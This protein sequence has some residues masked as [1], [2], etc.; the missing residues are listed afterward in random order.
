MKID[1][2][3]SIHAL[4]LGVFL[5]S[6]LVVSQPLK[7]YSLTVTTTD[8]RAPSGQ[9]SW[10]GSEGFTWYRHSVET[11]PPANLLTFLLLMQPP[12]FF[13]ESRVEA[14][15]ELK[16]KHYKQN[17]E[18]NDRWVPDPQ[19]LSHL[20][21]NTSRV[22]HVLQDYPIDIYWFFCGH[23]RQAELGPFKAGRYQFTSTMN[24]SMSV[25]GSI[26]FLDK[27]P[28]LPGPNS[29]SKVGQIDFL[30]KEDE[31]WDWRQ[32]RCKD[33]DDEEVEPN[34]CPDPERMERL[35][36]G[37]CVCK[38]PWVINP[39]VVPLDCITLDE[40]TQILQDQFESALDELRQIWVDHT[41]RWAVEVDVCWTVATEDLPD[42]VRGYYRC[43][44]WTIYYEVG[45]SPKRAQ[46]LVHD[47][48]GW[49]RHPDDP[50]PTAPIE[51]PPYIDLLD[52]FGPCFQVNGI[53]VTPCEGGGNGSELPDLL[54]S[55]VGLANGVLVAGDPLRPRFTVANSGATTAANSQYRVTYRLPDGQTRSQ[56]GWIGSLGP[57][58]LRGFEVSSIDNIAQPFTATPGTF[59]I[60][61]EVD[62][63][64]Q[65]SEAQEYNN[66]QQ[67]SATATGG[68]SSGVDL[69]VGPIAFDLSNP[70]VGHHVSTEFEIEN[71]GTQTAP[72]SVYRFRAEQ[73]DGSLET[74]T[75]PVPSLGPGDGFSSSQTV[76]LEAAGAL[77]VRVDAD[78]SSLIAE[79]DEDNNTRSHQ[80]QVHP[81][82]PCLACTSGDPNQ[83]GTRICADP[84]IGPPNLGA[85]WECF[86]VRPDGSTCEPQGNHPNGWGWA[87]DR[88]PDP[89]TLCEG[90]LHPDRCG[91]PGIC[92]GTLSCN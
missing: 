58:A 82:L 85:V 29:V 64:Q 38:L 53:P 12:T 32:E 31:V 73:G 41:S 10:D 2:R 46:S 70:A 11:A 9:D 22:C 91:N 75:V 77:R 5:A 71:L 19:P 23:T 15:V 20:Q 69:R 68:Q 89:G 44:T 6:C 4:T 90:D 47:G 79:S 62:S 55:S 88:C 80:V 76:L 48:L 60:D 21:Q 36:T 28:P 74:R 14:T 8:W 26:P 81:D 24:A 18:L 59:E 3:S 40:L 72:A 84:N 56:S 13:I 83:I 33:P 54:L 67:L 45:R 66:D 57:G 78:W 65:V 16:A 86:G 61:I 39:G 52:A 17:G 92:P 51:N 49:S 37:E 1:I 63:L 87:D 43:E 30:C 34:T 7:A 42:G 50:N 25:I 35:S 27:L